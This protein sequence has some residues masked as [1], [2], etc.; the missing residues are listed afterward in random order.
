M[1]IKRHFSSDNFD[2]IRGENQM[3]VERTEAGDRL[4]FQSEDGNRDIIG[5]WLFIAVPCLAL[6]LDGLAEDDVGIVWIGLFATCGVLL[7]VLCNRIATGRTIIMDKEGCTVLFGRYRKHY[8]WNEL[9]LKRYV[10]DYSGLGDEIRRSGIGI[11][12]RE[13][14]IFS[15]H[16]AKQL[17][18]MST[19]TYCYFMKPLSSIFVYFY[20]LGIS[21]GHG[22]HRSQMEAY[23]E[24]TGKS[25]FFTPVGVTRKQEV[26]PADKAEFLR[27]M[28]LWDIEIEGLSEINRSLYAEE[29]QLL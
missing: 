13:G 18:W 16:K 6:I 3:K 27:Y 23:R 21:D 8:Y 1:L 22:D 28:D 17:K 20:P 24:R 7:I 14:I 5:A 9:I 26:Y 19:Y 12:Y 4:V 10:F 15:K 29:R 2:Y 11:M 25:P